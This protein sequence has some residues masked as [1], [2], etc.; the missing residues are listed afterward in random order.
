VV[1]NVAGY[2]LGKLLVGSHGSLGVI[3]EAT[4][5]LM[6]R[7]PASRTVE[8]TG[9]SPEGLTR[10]ARTV[11]SGQVVPS[12]IEVTWPPARALVRFE[13][14]TQAVLEQAEE[15]CEIAR[16]Q[17]ASASVL[18]LEAEATC[19]RDH[20]A[21]LGPDDATIMAIGLPGS[22]I[23]RELDWLGRAADQHRVEVTV[24]G[25]L[26]LGSLRAALRGSV[27]AQAAM[28][29]ELRARRSETGGHV[30]VLRASD[31]LRRRVEPWGPLGG[32]ARIMQAVKARFDPN[33]V[34]NPGRWPFEQEVEE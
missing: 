3:V 11:A 8:V 24:A 5:K 4:F 1:K 16:G 17:G 30:V 20:A 28:L 7:S 14:V 29:E 10:F 22:E 23:G 13:S 32:A 34:L 27:D 25:R 6:P 21:R 33:G 12:A 15:T 9:A 31:D 19:W 18:G 2:D 26:A